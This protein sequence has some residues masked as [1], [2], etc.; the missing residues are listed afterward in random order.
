[1]A[2][3]TSEET[4]SVTRSFRFDGSMLKVLEEEAS[5]M[6]VSVNAL[7]NIVLGRFSEF[8]RYLSKV[9]MVVINREI[10][11][12]LLGSLEDKQILEIG[13]ILGSTVMP[14]TVMFWRKEITEQTVLEYIENAV[15]KYG[16]LGTFDEMTS[17]R[18]RTIVIRHRLG[19]KGS[20]FLEAY[21][22]AGLLRTL[23]IRAAF[24]STDSSIK[25]EMPLA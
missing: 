24:E 3:Y 15:C 6:G 7:V 10:L 22:Q 11:M 21:L 16:H 23:N 9:D 5:H 25:C 17:G 20:R 14:D 4:G 13:R 1:V 8:T 12:A 19:K 18:T 2:T